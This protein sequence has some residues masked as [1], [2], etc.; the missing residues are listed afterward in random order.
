MRN[1]ER[2]TRNELWAVDTS[3]EVV[4]EIVWNQ[5][6]IEHNS[7]RLLYVFRSIYIEFRSIS[8]EIRSIYSPPK[9]PAA[10]T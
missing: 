5:S 3:Y 9:Y 7:M 4:I 8:I 2:G 1:K 6:P 10:E